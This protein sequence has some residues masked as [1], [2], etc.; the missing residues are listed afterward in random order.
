MTTRCSWCLTADHEESECSRIAQFRVV[1]DHGIVDPMT[2][3]D[4]SVHNRIHALRA[5]LRGV[6]VEARRIGLVFSP[7]TAALIANADSFDP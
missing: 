6:L 2:D 3:E 7:E 1:A 5:A 4:D